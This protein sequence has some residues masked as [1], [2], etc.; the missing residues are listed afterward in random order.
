MANQGLVGYEM[1]HSWNPNLNDRT[2]V[3]HESCTVPLT[4]FMDDSHWINDS[5]PKLQT[6]LEITTS[7]NNLNSI[8]TNDDKAVLLSTKATKNAND[9]E[10][11][12]M[13]IGTNTINITPLPLNASTRILNVWLTAG[14][15]NQHIIKQIKD[16]VA[17]Y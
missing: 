17:S 5:T 3:K 2:I 4:A 8:L 15:S 13:T 16:E 9:C 14:K 12:T 10:P 11:L 7:F 1:S 6:T